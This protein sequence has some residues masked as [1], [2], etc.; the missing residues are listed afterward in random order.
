M[1]NIVLLKELCKSENTELEIII[2]D[3][4]SNVE[5]QK[6]FEI[7]KKSI[8]LLIIEKDNGQYDA[9]NK[10]LTHVTGEYW[11]WLNTDDL[12]DIDGLMK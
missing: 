1:K 7:Y 10:G 2:C 12:I 9:I 6:I 3:N 8:D 4:C 11:T 5:I